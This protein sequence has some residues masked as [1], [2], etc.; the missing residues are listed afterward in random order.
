[1]RWSSP[2]T[3]GNVVRQNLGVGAARFSRPGIERVRGGPAGPGNVLVDKLRL[4]DGWACGGFHS[5][6]AV[7]KPYGRYAVG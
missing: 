1:M 2:A 5:A 7:A 3:V 6:T 4:S